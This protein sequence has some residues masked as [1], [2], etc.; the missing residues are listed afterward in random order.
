MIFITVSVDHSF[1]PNYSHSSGKILLHTEDNLNFYKIPYAEGT[2]LVPRAT[3]TRCE[4]E[5]MKA[6]CPGPT[7]CSMN[8]AQCMVHPFVEGCTYGWNYLDGLAQKICNTSYGPDC[9]ALEM[10]TVFIHG[11]DA[12]GDAVIPANSDAYG[13]T[14][15]WGPIETGGEKENTYYALCVECNTCQGW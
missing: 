9:P 4:E 1:S 8:S 7:G 10:V 3:A 14:A 2:S 5:G 13:N 12:Q 11:Y 15:W 6:A